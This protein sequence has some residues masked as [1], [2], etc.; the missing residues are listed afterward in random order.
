VKIYG[1]SDQGLPIE[2]IVSLELAEITVNATPGELRKMAAFFSSAADNMERMGAQYSHEHLADR[3][4]GFD[5]SP[6]LTIFNSEDST[7]R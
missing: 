5:K 6:H 1:Y 3:Q 4:S 2:E 7:E